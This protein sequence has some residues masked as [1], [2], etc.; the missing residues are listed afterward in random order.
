MNQKWNIYMA[1]FM[2]T[3]FLLVSFWPWQFND[4]ST[5]FWQTKQC[6]H[7]QRFTFVFVSWFITITQS[8]FATTTKMKV[9][10]FNRQ[11]NFLYEF[12]KMKF[13]LYIFAL[14]R[15]YPLPPPPKFLLKPYKDILNDLGFG[16]THHTSYRI[17]LLHTEIYFTILKR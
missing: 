16:S 6:T 3:N 9:F 13:S 8:P 7:F 10:Q 5:D 12:Y 2:S 14:Y 15:I 1:D 17:V 4:I 11:L